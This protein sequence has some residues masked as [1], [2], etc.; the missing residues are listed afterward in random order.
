MFGAK[1][2]DEN[3]ASQPET[4]PDGAEGTVGI[5]IAAP[6]ASSQLLCRSPLFF[7]ETFGTRTLIVIAEE[8]LFSKILLQ[9]SCIHGG[10]STRP[11]GLQSSRLLQPASA[12]QRNVLS[13]EPPESRL[14]CTT[15]LT[16]HGAHSNPCLHPMPTSHAQAYIPIAVNIIPPEAN[17][18]LSSYGVMDSLGTCA[19]A[20]ALD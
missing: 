17:I 8:P 15:T 16:L 14:P 1:E 20:E 3:C 18:A 2:R 11:Y 7:E 19:A 6:R 9:T 10:T 4:Y 5:W 13:A 12:S